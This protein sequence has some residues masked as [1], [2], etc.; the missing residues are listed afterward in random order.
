MVRWMTVIYLQDG[1]VAIKI[2]CREDVANFKG[3]I[4]IKVRKNL[5]M[6]EGNIAIKVRKNLNMDEGTKE[7]H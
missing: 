7:A 1:I 2:D 3:K 5:N 4:A 6:D